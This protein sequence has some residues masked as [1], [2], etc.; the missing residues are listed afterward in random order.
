MSELQSFGPIINWQDIE[1]KLDSIRSAEGG[2]SQ[3][4]KGFWI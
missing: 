4:K 2:F 3:V 1:K